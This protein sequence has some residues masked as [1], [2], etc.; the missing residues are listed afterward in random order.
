MGTCSNG[1][2]KIGTT[3]VTSAGGAATATE[4]FV[5]GGACGSAAFVGSADGVGCLSSSKA[6]LDAAAVE[7]AA[8]PT[9]S[10]LAPLPWMA[11]SAALMRACR[12]CAPASSLSS[13]ERP[14]RLLIAAARA[15]SWVFGC[16]ARRRGG[17]VLGGAKRGRPATIPR[18]RSRVG[19]LSR[20][21]HTPH[22]NRGCV[23]DHL[24]P[25]SYL[26]PSGKQK[27]EPH[28]VKACGMFSSSP[29]F[30]SLLFAS[31]AHRG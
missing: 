22:H 5:A 6:K 31:D 13:S 4:A 19:L 3:C 1:R 2:E 15:C 17:G 26:P 11:S 21:P 29:P 12:F 16:R 8:S 9:G 24:P 10:V 20:P 23:V 14:P 25:S 27:P 7:E 18:S 30:A 28:H